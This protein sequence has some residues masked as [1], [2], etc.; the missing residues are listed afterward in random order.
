MCGIVGMIGRFN[1]GLF[2][3]TEDAFFQ[4]LFAD[5]L[6]GEDST[7][8][9]AIEKDTTFHIAKEASAASWFIP[10]FETGSVAKRMFNSGR[11]YIGHNRKKTI[12][13]LSDENAHPF[14][15]DDEF[16]MV[17]NG[18]LYQHK[19]L[20]DTEVDSEA[21]AIVLAEAF[22]EKDYKETLETTLG[23]VDGAYAVAMYDQRHNCVR[24]LRNKE[25]PLA[26]AQTTNAWFFASEA[27]MLG[28]ILLR[29]GYN[30]NDLK[31]EIVPEHTVI[32]FDLDKNEKTEE[33]V[34]PKKPHS[35]VH[36]V[37][38]GV[39]KTIMRGHTND[40]LSKQ[41]F[42]KL[43]RTWMNK[44]LQFWAEDFIETNFPKM[45][46]DGETLMTLMGVC[47]DIDEDN[48]VSAII[49]LKDFNLKSKEITDRVWV[50][51][52]YQMDYE[53][54]IGKVFFRME[55]AYPAPISK[56]QTIDAEYIR[57]KLDAQEKAKLTVH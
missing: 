29:N 11:A 13:T 51:R 21:L 44:H 12:G 35:P 37:A 32:T 9:I 18:T 48:H 57:R 28:W 41:G 5:T 54:K 10:T 52:V 50:G 40:K 55:K 14:V 2:K 27:A 53:P 22:K 34:T 42:K 39:M 20:A 36:S 16:A 49:D 45:E 43:R 6:R 17:H 1:N 8:V 23:K 56:P 7:G 46:S 47:D 30:P 38:T 4:L 19:T 31:I 26:Y 15:V 25:R 3:Q 24:L 33:K